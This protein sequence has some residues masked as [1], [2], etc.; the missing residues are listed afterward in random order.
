MI[1]GGLNL[2]FKASAADN[3]ALIQ[4]CCLRKDLFPIELTHNFWKNSK[5]EKL[6]EI[7]K[8]NVWDSGCSNC[9]SLESSNNISFRTGMNNGL[10]IFGQTNLSGPARIDLMFDISCNLACRSCGPESS[11]Y[12]QRHLKENK[13]WNQPISVPRKKIE[14]IDALSKLDL[15]NLKQLV[16]C[17]GETLLG[18]EYW[19]V[20]NWL[21]DNVPR[22]KEQL[23]LCFQTNGTQPI[24]PRNFNT[25]EKFHLVKLHISLDGTNRRFEYLRW[26]ANWNQVTDN[27]LNLRNT[28]P[29]NTMFVI[30]E[31]VSIFNLLYLQELETWVN[32]NFT[33]NKEG[34]VVNHTRHL[35][36]GTFNLQ[37]MS[38]E[39]VDVIKHSSQKNLIPTNWTEKPVV[40]QNMLAEIKK[41]DNFRN[42]SFEKV[43]PE[44]SKLYARFL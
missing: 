32:A 27:I 36:M 38:Q 30:E 25:I 7:N 34:D 10:E 42:E 28:L 5:L 8:Q 21:G 18:Q 12:W 44:L 17:G 1:H 43:F 39:Y 6:R 24:H 41:F 9:E 4:H 37:N 14:V 23:T 33:T 19:D 26:P 22:A 35:A 2:D 20:A 15:S 40:I 31:T 3:Q 29:R 16:F 13:L 11:T